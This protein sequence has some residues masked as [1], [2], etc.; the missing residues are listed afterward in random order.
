MRSNKVW[1]GVEEDPCIAGDD[2]LRFVGCKLCQGNVENFGIAVEEQHS[3]LTKDEDGRKASSNA[4]DADDKQ[5]NT[6][7]CLITYLN[8][9]K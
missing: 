7:A 6:F 2:A 1:V 3:V 5:T 4:E 8:A 9:V